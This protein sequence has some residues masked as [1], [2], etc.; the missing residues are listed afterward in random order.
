MY[1]L[2]SEIYVDRQHALCV[3]MGIVVSYP[4]DFES[5]GATRSLDQGA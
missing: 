5:V 3:S 2:D 1:L 4:W